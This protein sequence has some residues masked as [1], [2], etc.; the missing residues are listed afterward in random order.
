MIRHSCGHKKYR[1]HAGF[2]Y[3]FGKNENSVHE[4]LD[5]KRAK[6]RAIIQI[7]IFSPV[8][9]RISKGTVATG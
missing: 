7:T 4:D 6:M 1:K 5:V 9:E 3:A 2:I 8:L